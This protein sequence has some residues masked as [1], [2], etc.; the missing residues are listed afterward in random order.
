MRA[1]NRINRFIERLKIRLFSQHSWNQGI[2]TQQIKDRSYMGTSMEQ[3]PVVTEY[4]SK[5]LMM[6]KMLLVAY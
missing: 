4:T 3:V 6:P 1:I 5:H 2:V